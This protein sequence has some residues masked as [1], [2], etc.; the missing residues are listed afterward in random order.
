MN[1]Q[2]GGW[3]GLVENRARTIRISAMRKDHVDVLLLQTFEGL[4]RALDDT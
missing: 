4:F 3:G 2:T 1:R